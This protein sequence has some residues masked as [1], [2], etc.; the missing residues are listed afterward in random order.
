MS[1]ADESSRRD[2][3]VELAS[4][5]LK[6]PVMVASGTF[7]YGREYAEYFDL[8]SLGAVMV[9]GVSLEPW[10]GNRPPRITETPA[11]MLNAIGLQN[12]GWIISSLL[13]WLADQGDH[14]REHCGKDSRRIRRVAARL[15]Q[16]PG[17]A[18]WR[19]IYPVPMSRKAV[20]PSA[21]TSWRRPL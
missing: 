10:S 20:S 17:V 19:S 2:L 14:D 1:C 7:G 4:L 13:P 8:S 21:P 6:N 9:K 5:V 3:Q 11:G 12:P 15:N 18:R 16:A